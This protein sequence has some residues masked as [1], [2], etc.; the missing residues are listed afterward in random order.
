MKCNG[1]LNTK[2]TNKQEMKELERTGQEKRRRASGCFFFPFLS[3]LFLPFPPTVA[4]SPFPARQKN[5]K[6]P[7]NHTTHVGKERGGEERSPEPIPRASNVKICSSSPVDKTT[8][9]VTAA[10]MNVAKNTKQGLSE[11]RENDTRLSKR[12]TKPF[13]SESDP[14]FLAVREGE[15]QRRRGRERY[16]HIHR[17][18]LKENKGKG[19]EF[20]FLFLPSHT[21][22][23]DKEECQTTLSAEWVLMNTPTSDLTAART[24]RRRGLLQNPHSETVFGQT[25]EPV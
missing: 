12:R 14:T 13:T 19:S 17:D 20:S 2:G 1:P 21:I 5:N 9:A 25:Q 18:R 16:T 24:L 22:F 7:K 3:V 10:T 4:N 6:A 15:R 8:A 11:R 23:C